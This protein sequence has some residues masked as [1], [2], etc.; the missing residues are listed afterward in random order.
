MTSLA[1]SASAGHGLFDT[2]RSSGLALLGSLYERIQRYRTYNELVGMD[3][4][5]LADMGLTRGEIEAWY[6]G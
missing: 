1:N 3:D 6:R 2:L 4:R 5:L